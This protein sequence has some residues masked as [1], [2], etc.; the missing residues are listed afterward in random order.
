MLFCGSMASVQTPMF[1]QCKRTEVLL[2]P[3]TCENSIEF[4]LGLSPI[5]LFFSL[6]KINEYK[7]R[8]YVEKYSIECI[9][10]MALTGRP[11]GAETSCDRNV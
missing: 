6:L 2:D 1:D 9:P 3:R 4:S 7:H 10:T 11:T 8:G 5:C